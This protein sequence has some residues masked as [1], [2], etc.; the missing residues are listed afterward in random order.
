MPCLS[1]KVACAVSTAPPRPH[2]SASNSLLTISSTDGRAEAAA[3]VSVSASVSEG[4][5]KRIK[6]LF[7][8][9]SLSFQCRFDRGLARVV[10]SSQPGVSRRLPIVS[11]PQ[12]HRGHDH[13]REETGDE[14]DE[15]Q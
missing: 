15:G 6:A 1:L 4:V 3:A 7:M 9:Q 12:Q 10:G 11:D 14:G 2:G 13:I 8:D 5:R